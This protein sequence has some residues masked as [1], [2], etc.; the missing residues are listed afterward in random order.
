LPIE[1]KCQT[2]NPGA[3]VELV[4]DPILV[5]ILEWQSVEGEVNTS[6]DLVVAHYL[7]K[8]KALKW[9]V[10]KLWAFRPPEEM[11]EEL[12]LPVTEKTHVVCDDRHTVNCCSQ[13]I[14]V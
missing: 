10:G 11:E 14:S 4:E 6:R 7:H 3:L 2:Q 8:S 5:V 13:M 1:G 9:T 12:V